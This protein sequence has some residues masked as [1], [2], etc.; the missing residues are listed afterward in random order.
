MNIFELVQ[1]S[2]D[3]NHTVRCVSF[4]SRTTLHSSLIQSKRPQ[5]VFLPTIIWPSQPKVRYTSFPPD[6][7]FG[8]IVPLS[9]NGM[10]E[11]LPQE[12]VDLI[13]D[14]LYFESADS[15]HWR[16]ALTCYS[17]S[18]SRLRASCLRWLFQS[19]SLANELEHRN[20]ASFHE[21]ITSSPR[22]VTFIQELQVRRTNIQLPS[23]Q[24]ILSDLPQLQILLLG[25]VSLHGAPA[26]VKPIPLCSLSLSYVATSDGIMLNTLLGLFSEI[27]HFKLH[28]MYDIQRPPRRSQISSSAQ[29]AVVGGGGDGWYYGCTIRQGPL[30]CYW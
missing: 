29:A 9:R 21:L 8:I 28:V 15:L 26:A 22:L 14:Q 5:R 30:P 7:S 13:V 6:N 24:Q 12:L 19:V 1:F 17:M 18:S 16:E 25:G 11:N 3:C 2:L 4:D 20:L 10:M 23:L 27:E